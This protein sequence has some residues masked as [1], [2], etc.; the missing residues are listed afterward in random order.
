[1]IAGSFGGVVGGANNRRFSCHAMHISRGDVLNSAGPGVA[2]R[3]TKREDNPKPLMGVPDGGWEEIGESRGKRT[4]D[5]TSSLEA[6]M[7]RNDC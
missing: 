5:D 2:L 1:M 4:I 7:A 6:R 3:L